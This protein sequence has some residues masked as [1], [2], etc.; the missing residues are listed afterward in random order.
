MFTDLFDQRDKTIAH[1]VKLGDCLGRSIRENVSLFD[2]RGKNQTVSYVTEGG[3]VISGHYNLDG[4]VSIENILIQDAE[5]FSNEERF[6]EHVHNQISS[7]I[8]N[9]HFND[10][11]EA[12]NTFDD[13]LDLWKSRLKFVNVQNR[14]AEKTQSLAEVERIVES[15]EF[16]SLVE[17]IP[18]LESFLKENLEK[19]LSVPEIRNAVNLSNTV[20][21]AFN[22]PRLTLEE[23]EEGGT[24]T[25]KDGVE[26]SIYEMICRQELVKKEISESK[27]NFETIWATNSTI[28]DLASCIFEDDEK[29]VVALGKAIKE[30]PYL[31]LA[32]K[33]TLTDTFANCLSITEGTG[34]SEKDIQQYSSKIFEYKKEVKAAL[35]NDLSERYGV[36]IQNLN[37]PVSFKSLA[38]TQVVIFETLSRLAPNGSVL[39]RTLSEIGQ[40]L[41]TK[42]GVECIDVNDFLI[43]MF[44]RV[45]YDSIIQEDEEIELRKSDFRRLSENIGDFGEL[46]TSLKFTLEEEEDEVV[47]EETTEAEETEQAE[48]E[49]TEEETEE[50]VEEA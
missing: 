34:L 11:S 10:L 31:A 44:I 30:I 15:D 48:E 19:V 25:L 12:S 9:I 45:G 14:L 4:D 38:N 20:S 8:G 41:K 37:E 36:N 50:T 40:A 13:V 16:Q 39:K 42:S 32:S 18:Q 49:S 47:E 1:L 6:D 33:R 2:I 27:K 17:I 5:V 24:Y 28:Q 3:K 46:V 35:V 29:V 21:N 23:L 7:F 22:F 26:P 43:E